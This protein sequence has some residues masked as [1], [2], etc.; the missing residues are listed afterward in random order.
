MNPE[1]TFCPNRACS[2]RRHGAKAIFACISISETSGT[3][4]YRIPKPQQDF[5]RVVTLL[6][7]GCPVQ[8]IVA[9][10]SLQ[11]RADGL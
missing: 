2:A 11:R 5:G 4:L 3:A 7:H 8:V 9:A 10:G 1:E 6:G